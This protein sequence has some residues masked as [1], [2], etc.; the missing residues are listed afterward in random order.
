MGNN[1]DA[2]EMAGINYKRLYVV[3]F[4]ISGALAAMGGFAEVNGVQHML[5]QG[6]NPDVSAAGIGI[7]I[8]RTATQSA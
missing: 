4:A 5:V 2:A 3:A 8:W 1:K 6:F 7:A